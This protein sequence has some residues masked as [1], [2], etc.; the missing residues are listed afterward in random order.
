MVDDGILYRYRVLNAGVRTEA[1]ATETFAIEG[2]DSEN[3]IG[4]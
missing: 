1:V 2:Q 4:E 3:M